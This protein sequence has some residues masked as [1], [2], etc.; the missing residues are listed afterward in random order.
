MEVTWKSGIF[1][2]SVEV[3]EEEIPGGAMVEAA[4]G[5]GMHEKLYI[6]SRHRLQ[7]GNFSIFE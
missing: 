6:I 4:D 7:V 3:I 1:G 2:G 5:V